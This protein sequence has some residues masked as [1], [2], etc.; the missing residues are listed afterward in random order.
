MKEIKFFKKDE[1]KVKQVLK[2][3]QLR[4]VTHDHVMMTLFDF[5]PDD[6]VM[7]NHHHPHE[8]ISYVLK[9]AVT[10]V[11]GGESRLLK[12]GHGVVIPPDVEHEVTSVEQDSQ[13]LDVFYPLREDYLS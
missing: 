5:G 13:L 12:A 10:M 8:Q 9:G 3:S 7:P 6:L 2:S 1:L 4:A 11:V